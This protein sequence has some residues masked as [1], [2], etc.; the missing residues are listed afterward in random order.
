LGRDWLSVH[1]AVVFGESRIAGLLCLAA[2]ALF[3]G[4]L[5]GG[6]GGLLL[7]EAVFAALAL[8]EAM[9]PGVRV[10]ALLTGLAA[11]AL[12][13]AVG[14]WWLVY[15]LAVLLAVGLSVWLGELLWRAGQLPALSLPFSLAIWTAMPVL[16]GLAPAA[17]AVPALIAPES[18]AGSLLAAFGWIF[19]SPHPL[20]GLLVLAALLLA[21]RWF[22]L[23]AAAGVAAGQAVMQV[24]APE[25]MGPGYAFN[26]PLAAMAVGGFFCR[27]GLGSFVLALFAAALAALV[28]AAFALAFGAGGMPPLSVPFVLATLLVLAT[29]RHARRGVVTALASP[30]LPERQAEAARLARARLGAPGSL[31]L[32]P[33]FLGEWQVYQGFDGPHTHR[34][35]WRHALDFFITNEGRS[36]R[37]CGAELSDYMCFGLPVLAPA[38]GEVVTSRDGLPDNPPGHVDTRE[39]WGNHIVIR[40]AEGSHVWLAHLRQGSVAVTAGT[41][42]RAGDTVGACGNSGRSPQPHLHLHVQAGGAAGAAS[43]PFHLDNVLVRAARGE[44]A[45]GAP[46]EDD[47]GA[48]EWRLACVP[49]Q[50]DGVRAARAEAALAG[51]LSVPVGRRLGF[52]VRHGMDAWRPWSV[53]TTL[54]LAGQLRLTGERASLAVE[55]GPHAFALYDRQGRADPWLDLFA[56]ALGLTPLTEARNWNDAPPARHFPASPAARLAL[57]F[58]HPL[59]CALTSR[60]R[61]ERLA[62]PDLWRQAGRHELRIAPGWREAFETTADIAP[63][64]GIVRI[65][66]RLGDRV[67]EMRLATVGQTADQGIPSW[68]VKVVGEVPVTGR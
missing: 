58:G 28:S 54:T 21:S 51:A 43:L 19:L 32:A 49:G 25:A 52:E 67:M 41:W 17:S 29:A 39:N 15:P 65:E 11:V 62:E 16:G 33:P 27:P 61:R 53:E 38:A 8:P 6:L 44:P 24:L 2:T 31:P 22:F 66:G 40:T 30:A 1:A 12:W 35:P 63:V 9:R 42:V 48:Q 46:H 45:P 34:G 26:F 18:A 55:P 23:L 37:D 64:E 14:A 7:A 59:G 47:D 5:L 68:Q 56:L 20:S 36:F 60:Y 4:V 50:G 57:W 13:P 10:N 3:P